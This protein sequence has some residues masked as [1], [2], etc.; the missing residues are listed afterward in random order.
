[1][2]VGDF[3]GPSETT[4]VKVYLDTYEAEE[5][6]QQVKGV[7]HDAPGAL[8]ARPPHPCRLLFNRRSTRRCMGRLEERHF[9]LTLRCVR[10]RLF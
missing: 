4:A 1:M 5:G 3:C 8:P 7:N 6:H 9:S 10:H 2:R